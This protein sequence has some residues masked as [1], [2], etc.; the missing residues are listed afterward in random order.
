M[1]V[2]HKKVEGNVGL[3]LSSAADPMTKDRG[4]ASFACG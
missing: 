3:V 1:D 4:N 2:D